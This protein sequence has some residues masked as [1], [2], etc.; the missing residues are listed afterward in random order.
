MDSLATKR[1]PKAV[2]EALQNPP[3]EIGDTYDKAMQRIEATNDDDRKIAMNF[4]LWIAFSAR[5]LSVAE[6]EHASAISDRA[7]DVE[8]DEILGAGDLTSL[9]AGLVIIDASEI[10]RFVHLSAQR[11]FTENRE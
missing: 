3:R 5:P 7:T 4:L 11:Y 9:C 2:Q 1:T 6:V 10:V 8:Q